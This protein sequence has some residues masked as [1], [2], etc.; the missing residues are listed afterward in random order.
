ML[1]DH[2]EALV[3]IKEACKWV[4]F[5]TKTCWEFSWVRR[6]IQVRLP[7]VLKKPPRGCSYSNLHSHTLQI[8]QHWVERYLSEPSFVSLKNIPE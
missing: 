7:V 8:Y 1:Q 2:V 3:V 4:T 6:Q 5:S